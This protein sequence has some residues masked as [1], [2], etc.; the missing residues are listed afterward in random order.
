VPEKVTISHRGTKYEIGRGKRY[1]GIWVNGAPESDP[2]DRWPETRDGWTQ[3]WTRFTTIE[4]PGT[5]QEAARPRA[6]F[7]LPRV[8]L[9]AR[10][11]RTG[12]SARALAGAGLLGLGV[13]LGLI[14]LFPGYIGSPSLAS[15][16]YQLVP[17]LCYL[18]TWI[19]SAVLIVVGARSSR[20][21]M[22]RTGA[23]LGIGLSAVTF[24]LFLADL[25]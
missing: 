10:R 17:H 6:K 16:A 14:G 1:Y 5:I 24:G 25:C 8:K 23:L 21:G 20:P 22:T 4:T 15:Q 7:A 11:P 12:G 2:I 9:G 3:A 13:L 18:A 19:V